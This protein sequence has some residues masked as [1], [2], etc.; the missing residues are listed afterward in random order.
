[1]TIVTE[2]QDRAANTRC[3][4]KLAPHCFVVRA[5]CAA[6]LGVSVGPHEAVRVRQSI[7]YSQ[8]NKASRPAVGHIFAPALR[9]KTKQLFVGATGVMN[10]AIDDLTSVHDVFP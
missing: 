8:R 2:S 5:R 4:E 9:Q 3:I 6:I 10:I 1:M 7:L